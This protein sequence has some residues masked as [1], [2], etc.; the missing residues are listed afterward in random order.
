MFV[1]V[2]VKANIAVMPDW[3]IELVRIRG[4]NGRYQFAP[5]P[6]DGIRGDKIGSRQLKF[7]Q[8]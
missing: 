1:Q 2:Y 4:V 7:N 8:K 5:Y 3:C 6:K